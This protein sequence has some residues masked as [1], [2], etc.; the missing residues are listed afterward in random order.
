VRP[1]GFHHSEKTKE[2][3]REVHKGKTPWN[4]GLHIYCGGQ[5][6]IR[7]QAPWNKGKSSPTK[8]IDLTPSSELSY[9]LGVLAGDGWVNVSHFGT[10]K[11]GLHVSN[12]EFAEEF[13][14]SLRTIGF[15]PC[16]YPYTNGGWGKK[17]MYSVEAAGRHFTDWYLSLKIDD[18][19]NIVMQYPSPFV[20]G[21]YQSEGTVGV[22]VVSMCNKRLDRIILVQEAGRLLRYD[23][24][25]HTY[26][27]KPD[28]FHQEPLTY[29][30]LDVHGGQ[31]EHLRFLRI[32][33]EHRLADY[34]V[35]N[36]VEAKSCLN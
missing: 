8:K 33:G 35:R 11:V 32:F 36:K 17:L 23:L 24:G 14:Q 29:Y 31:T 6:F 21:F 25:V 12:K 13:A 16:V 1:K 5:R 22:R 26:I 7:G 4:K 34:E 18:I 19:R 15:R 10:Y 28:K 30:V 20:R 9:I 27:R 3:L 2:H